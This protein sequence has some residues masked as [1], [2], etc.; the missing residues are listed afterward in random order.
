VLLAFVAG[1]GF[2]TGSGQAQLSS[3]AVAVFLVAAVVFFLEWRVMAT[4]A[5]DERGALA[6][7]CAPNG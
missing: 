6:S 2:S 7:A 1:V 5:G 3:V 4:S